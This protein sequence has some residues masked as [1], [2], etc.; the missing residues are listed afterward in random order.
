MPGTAITVCARLPGK[1][2]LGTCGDDPTLEIRRWPSLADAVAVGRWLSDRKC[3][4]HCARRHF[5]LFKDEH[6]VHVRSVPSRKPPRT[7]AQQFRDCYKPKPPP[8]LKRGELA[9]PP[10]KDWPTPASFNQPLPPRGTPVTPETQRQ[11]DRAVEQACSKL[12][13]EPGGLAARVT[14]AHDAGDEQLAR[15]LT[16]AV[17]AE[18]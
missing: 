10:P 15:A 6:G 16:D 8:K 9:P 1:N 17:M 5:I 13:P 11:Q 12:A 4:K 3:S 7:R 18:L 2:G 14:A